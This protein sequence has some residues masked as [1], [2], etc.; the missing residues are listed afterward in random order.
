MQQKLDLSSWVYHG[1]NK[2]TL[3]D[4]GYTTTFSMDRGI[5]HNQKTGYPEKFVLIRR[6]NSVHGICH[7]I[8]SKVKGISSNLPNETFDCIC[9]PDK[10]KLLKT[11]QLV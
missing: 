11:P 3:F 4:I 8:T 10:C 6:V 5:C 7:L 1:T 2:C 9:S